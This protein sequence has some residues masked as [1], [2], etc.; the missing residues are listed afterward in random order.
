M[1]SQVPDCFCAGIAECDWAIEVTGKLYQ[2]G[3][4]SN[5]IIEVPFKIQNLPGPAAQLIFQTAIAAV[6]ENGLKVYAEWLQE[7]CGAAS[8]EGMMKIAKDAGIIQ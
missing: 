6:N 1:S 5:T 3:D 2:K 8:A 4:L 7:I